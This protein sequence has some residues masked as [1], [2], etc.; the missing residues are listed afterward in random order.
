MVNIDE[1]NIFFDMESG[2]TLA[3]KGDKTV[4]LRT[5]GTSMWCTM[6]L[7]VTLNGEKLTPLVVFKGQPNGRIARTFNMMPA[8]MKYVCQAK[9]WVDQ[10]VFKHCIAE[11]WKPFTVERADKTYLLIDEFSVHLMATCCNA[12][13]ECGLEVDYILGDYSSKLQ[14]MDV[15]VNKPFKAM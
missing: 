3:N 9:A 13:K 5:T 7:G 14:V 1:T 10:R 11:V 12:I 6:L 8:S 15:G 2:L 4:S